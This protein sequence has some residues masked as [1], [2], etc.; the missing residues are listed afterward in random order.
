MNVNDIRKT[1]LEHFAE[2]DHEIVPSG[3][4]VPFNDPTLLFTNSGM[5]QFK[6]VFTEH[7]TRAIP[8]AVT[9]QK[10]V[11]AG[12]KHNDLENVGHTARHHTFFEMLGNFSFGD[13]FKEKAIHLAWHL[14]TDTFALPKD[15]LLVTIYH[16]DDEAAKW[17]R[18]IAGLKDDRIIRIKT[19]DNFWAMGDTGPC[20]PCSEVFYDHG[21]GIA[22]GPPGSPDEDGD[23]FIE[24]WNLVFMQF[25]QRAAND[26]V[27]LPKPSI[28]TGMGIERIA[29]IMQGVHDNY[30]IDLMQT[31]I[32]ASLECSG[33][34]GEGDDNVGHRVIA[35]HL[36]SSCF[37]IADGVLPSNEGRGYVLRRI[38]RRAMRHAHQMGCTDPLMYKLVPTLVTEMGDHY[39]ELRQ[40]QE[41]MTEV[42]KGEEERFKETLARG[43]KILT[44]EVKK[45]EG[46]GKVLSGEVAFRLYDTY[47]FPIDLTADVARG[48]GWSVDQTGF[49]AAMAKQ[50]ETAR[51]S[52]LGA[53]G[54]ALAPVY[55]ALDAAATEFLGYETL[56]TSAA[57][58]ALIQ[59]DAQVHEIGSGDQ[60]FLVV[61][62][63]PFYAESGGQI[64][65]HGVI[66]DDL[67]GEELAKVTDVWKTPSG[68]FFH[69]ITVTA[70]LKV[71]DSCLMRVDAERRR[72]LR[73][74]HSATHLLQEALRALL[75]K[76]ITQK[77]SM[78]SP[79]RLRF[80]FSHTKQVSPD[81]LAAIEELVNRRLLLNAEVTTRVMTKDDA[82]AEGALALFGEKYGDE[83]RV[84]SMGG[85]SEVE[86]KA[87]WSVELC[88]GT[89]VKRTG[90][91]GLFKIISESAVAGGVR[92]I[93]ALTCETAMRWLNQRL[94]ILEDSSRAI[95]TSPE[96]LADRVKTLLAD[97]RKDDTV[98]T[99]LRQ[100]LAAGDSDGR[101]DQEKIGDVIVARRIL[102][103][104]PA[105]E[106]KNIAD[107]IIKNYDQALV[108]LISTLE[109]KAS[110]VVGSTPSVA[111][112]CDAAALVKIG[113]ECLGGK[114]GGGRADMAQAGGPDAS[115]AEETMKAIIDHAREIL[116]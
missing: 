47:G 2:H 6:N 108:V 52:W 30:D 61:N 75:G 46:G 48:Y 15:R 110:L 109:G 43:L 10:C 38:M 115:K 76:H 73:C 36:R 32:R 104:T 65:D 55:T 70:P 58:T 68:V 54:E 9:A 17:W 74:N 84:V 20:G 53:G 57:I 4:L 44:D 28:D 21:E 81:E 79:D 77:G 92:R 40:A 100:R 45:G 8:R 59:N 95:K 14:L 107:G 19:S 60:A 103:D 99:G 49:D 63:T 50:K 64:A 93:E 7:E 11:R 97:K 22:G 37:L 86:N 87:A 33:T 105:K 31:L 27:P 39:T 26:R 78:V 98:I 82:Q 16:D 102:A 72:Y 113:A 25:E 23:R 94:A 83:V 56:Q 112:R 114:G 91:I 51:K 89:H 41:L 80:D 88:G 96:Q 66:I 18:K 67:S 90:E 24:I 34:G 12:G 5:V 62:Q 42:L 116:T 106:L 69:E 101:D 71:G 3:P 29:A 111:E 13:Y 1:F 85:A 35:D